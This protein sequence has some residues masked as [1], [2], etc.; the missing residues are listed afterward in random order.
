MLTLA[1]VADNKKI[2]PDKI[3]VRIGYRI[4]PGR[5]WLTS[6][7]IHVDLGNGLTPRERTILFNSARLC[8][9][10]KLLAGEKKFSYELTPDNEQ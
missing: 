7:Q 8:E 9:V 3:D 1:A 5:K 2:R 6:F 4:Q 10:S